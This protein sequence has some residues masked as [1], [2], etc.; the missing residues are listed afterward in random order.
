MAFVM[1]TVQLLSAAAESMA[2]LESA[3]RTLRRPSQSV[4]MDFM[5]CTRMMMWTLITIVLMMNS[6][7]MT[8]T[9]Y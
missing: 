6:S 5:R 8:S 3:Q 4:G 2:K 9:N 7:G 1:M